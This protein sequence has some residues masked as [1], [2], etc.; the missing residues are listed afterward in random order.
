M[1]SKSISQSLLMCLLVVLAFA[2]C[3]SPVLAQLPTPTPPTYWTGL[4]DGHNWFDCANW[5]NGC[6]DQSKDAFINNGG[7]V[8]INSPNAMARSLTI[9]LAQGNSGSLEVNGPG[10]LALPR[11]PGD[12]NLGAIY[13]G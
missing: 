6:P 10:S 8:I 11:C 13:V 1:R 5:D 7:G 3:A 2:I 4:G 12:S 9:G